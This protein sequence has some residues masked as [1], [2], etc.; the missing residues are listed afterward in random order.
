[1]STDDA[2]P[3]GPSELDVRLCQQAAL[4][5]FSVG[6]SIDLLERDDDAKA[7][8]LELAPVGATEEQPAL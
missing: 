3:E 8:V 7:S 5:Q 1:M 4:Q 2:G 6:R